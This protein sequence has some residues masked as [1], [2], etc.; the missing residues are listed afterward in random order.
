MAGL[1]TGDRASGRRWDDSERR[2]RPVFALNGIDA[3]RLVKMKSRIYERG[4][5]RMHAKGRFEK[6]CLHFS[7]FKER[8]GKETVRGMF[9]N[10]CM[11]A[12]AE[13]CF[14]LIG[15]LS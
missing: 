9:Y 10:F 2:L 11:I 7:F 15:Y 6:I 5:R 4:K 1:P 13:V 3:F 14:F 12:L 8:Y